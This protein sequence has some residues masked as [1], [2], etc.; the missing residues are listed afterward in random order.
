MGVFMLQVIQKYILGTDAQT[1]VVWSRAFG[2]LLLVY[3]CVIITTVFDYGITSDEPGHVAYG[4]AMTNWYVSGFQ[5]QTVFESKN[6]WLYGGLFDFGVAMVSRVLP[7]DTYAARHFCNALVGLLGVVAAYQLGVLLGGARAGFLAALFLVLMPRY[8]GHAFN[9]P[10]DIP[11]AVTYLWGVYYVIRCVMAYPFLSRGLIIKTGLTIGAA[12][13]IRVGGLLLVFYLGVFMLLVWWQLRPRTWSSFLLLAKQMFVMGGIAYGVAFVFWPY[14]QVHP[15]TGFWDAIQMFGAFPEIHFT[16]FEGIY[17][18]SNETPWYY[19]PKWLLLTLPEYILVGVVLTVGIALVKRRFQMPYLILLVSAFFPVVYAVVKQMP[20]YDGIRHLLF[21]MPPLAVVA[22]LGVNHLL[23]AHTKIAWATF[24]CV[25]LCVLFGLRNLIVLHPNQYVYFNHVLAGGVAEASLRYDTDY[26]ENSYEQGVAWVQA[27]PSEG[28]RR[29]RAHYEHVKLTLDSNLF[30]WVHLSED[31]DYYLAITRYD[32]HKLI[33][34]EILHTVE[35]DGAPLLC[36]IRPDT[37]Y[38]KD[39]FFYYAPYKYAYFGEFYEG[40]GDVKRAKKAYEMAIEMRVDTLVTP[41]RM[42]GYYRA[43]GLLHLNTGEMDK[44][45]GVMRQALLFDPT[46]AEAWYLLA[47]IL[48]ASGDYGPAQEAIQEA[49][50]LD[51]DRDTYV[52]EL[53]NIGVALQQKGEGVKALSIY[54]WALAK[55][56]NRTDVLINAGIA[57]F[58]LTDYQ[59]AIVMFEKAVVLSP[60]D[61]EIYLGLIQSYANL[62]DLKKALEYCQKALV[63]N[64]DHAEVLLLKKQLQTLQNSE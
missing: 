38:A 41:H 56:P 47:Q 64:P 6:T 34:G 50:V 8:Y 7:L 28:K 51:P 42:W 62:A 32:R 54:E 36:V 61:M 14:L 12:L 4:E 19:A 17:I 22:A 11:V 5:D 9:N 52:T 37:R 27:Q 46:Q 48:A 26:W 10:K 20:L 45:K 15:M 24:C 43:L 2:V 63:L 55:N 58:S 49:L 39:P 59:N 57:Y 40:F 31:A 13:A 16:F 35:A 3:F 53:I 60:S 23:Q 1:S 29:I 25:C 18:G 30:E 21:V 44:A 33:P